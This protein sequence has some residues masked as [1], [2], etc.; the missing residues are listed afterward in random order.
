MRISKWLVTGASGQMQTE[1][2]LRP[3]A[4][5][6]GGAA[7]RARARVPPVGVALLARSTQRAPS[8]SSDQ[9]LSSRPADRAESWRLSV[10]GS[11]A[12][13]LALGWLALM[14]GRIDL[15]SGLYRAALLGG[16]IGIA[17]WLGNSAEAAVVAAGILAGAWLHGGLLASLSADA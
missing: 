3:G 17:W 12:F 7:P 2:T 5:S 4:I 16:G 8:S 10:V 15:P 1:D 13:G 6:S 11:A 14:G 9:A